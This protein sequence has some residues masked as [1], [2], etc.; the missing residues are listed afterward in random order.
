MKQAFMLCG[1]ALL[2]ASCATGSS[3]LKE[4][5]GDIYLT[6]GVEALGSGDYTQALSSLKEAVK[7][8]PKAAEA[9]SNLGLA[10]AGKSDFVHAEGC[11]RKA[12]D[13]NAEFSDAR[14]NLGAL[15]LQQK[16]YPLAEKELKEVLKDLAYPRTAQA[17]YNLGLVYRAQGKMIPAQQYFKLAVTEDES[18]CPAWFSLGEIQRDHGNLAEATKSFLNSIKGTCFRNPRAHYELSNL[19]LRAK[20]NALAK[21]KLLEII[22]FFPQTEWAQKAELTLNMIR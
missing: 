22:Q 16:K 1:M 13:V 20:E 9:W 7:L 4:K 17:K 10:Y 19:Y 12:L 18:Y 21:S 11:F 14:L 2:L 3:K 5:Q 8:N 6:A 15:Y